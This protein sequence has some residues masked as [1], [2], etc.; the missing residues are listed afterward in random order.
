MTDEMEKIW[1]EEVVA[2][3]K[4]YPDTC[5]KRLR[6]NFNQDSR[7]PALIRN[8]HLP[9]TNLERCHYTSLLSN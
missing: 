4:Y 9:N 7:C 5:L 2:Y 8:G 6:K 1:K 3:S